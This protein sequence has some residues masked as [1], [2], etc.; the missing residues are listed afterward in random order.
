[1]TRRFVVRGM[2]QGVG[3][4][5]F[6]VRKA[7][8]LG[9]TGFVRNLADGTLEVVAEGPGPSL[10]ALESELQQGPPGAQVAG[11]AREEWATGPMASF[12]V[13]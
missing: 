6:V 1:M 12:E 3:F 9:L 2:V 13:R 7:R 8:S 5:W 11:V 10:V 4:R